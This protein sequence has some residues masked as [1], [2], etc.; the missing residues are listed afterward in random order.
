MR[1]FIPEVQAVIDKW[2]KTISEGGEFIEGEVRREIIRAGGYKLGVGETD[3]AMRAIKEPFKTEDRIREIAREEAREALGV[4][5]E[6]AKAKEFIGF[7]Y[8]VDIENIGI[9]RDATA[10]DVI[11]FER[12]ELGNTFDVPDKLLSELDNYRYKDVIWVTH[13]IEDAEVY[14]SEGMTPK[15]ISKFRLPPG[16]KI[17]AED[18]QGGFL[19]LMG[20]AKPVHREN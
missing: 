4:T 12:E 10:A 2:R 8:R 14:L 18:Q 13:T 20:D 9:P 3:R 19:I 7:A 6:I 11:R 17:I 5:P 1:E 15:D 16:S